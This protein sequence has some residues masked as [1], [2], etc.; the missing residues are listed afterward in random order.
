LN[1]SDV[2]L[3]ARVAEVDVDGCCVWLFEWMRSRR[4]EDH[5]LFCQAG[6]GIGILLIVGVTVVESKEAVAP[7]PIV[8]TLGRTATKI[9]PPPST[10]LTLLFSK[11]PG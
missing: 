7:G 10:T 5:H 6:T 8:T 9:I 1:G 2:E 3:K 11:A 4:Q